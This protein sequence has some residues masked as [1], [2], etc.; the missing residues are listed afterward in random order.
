[1][2]EGID[3][4][5]PIQSR[6]KLRDGIDSTFYSGYGR[7]GNE[8]TVLA[9]RLDHFGLPEIFVKWDQEHWAYNRQPD[10]WTFEEH[11]D[12]AEAPVSEDNMQEA[13]Q[14]LAS[15][16]AESLINVI[17]GQE[18]VKPVDEGSAAAQTAN[19]TKA[20][21][22]EYARSVEDA[23]EALKESESFIVVT[24]SRT[25]DPRAPEGALMAAIYEE[26][27]TP[28]AE[29]LVAAQAAAVVAR[30]HAETALRYVASLGDDE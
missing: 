25:D 7:V 19:E 26:A 27:F 23:V 14:A 30:K 24:V 13:I 8:G 10:C 22:K 1:M 4:K 16:F 11:F 17:G 28:E 15:G 2:M 9:H 12:P 6:V 5:Y 20:A 21:A 29:A 3:F 18:L